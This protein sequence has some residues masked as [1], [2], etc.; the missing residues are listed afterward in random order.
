MN[1]YKINLLVTINGEVI[2]KTETWSAYD[3][4][5]AIGQAFLYHALAGAMAIEVL[6]VEFII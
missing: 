4:K 5:G 2:E 3:E 6:S 1:T